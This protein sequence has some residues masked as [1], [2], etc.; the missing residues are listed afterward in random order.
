L[1]SQKISNYKNYISKFKIFNRFEEGLASFDMAIKHNPT[2]SYAYNNK[3]A[4]L[5]KLNRF[6]EALASFDMA[7]KHKPNYSLAKNNRKLLLKKLKS[8]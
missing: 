1:R 8:K 3:G 5:E 7:L 2:N 6:D 4:C